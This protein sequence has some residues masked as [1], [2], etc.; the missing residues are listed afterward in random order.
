VKLWKGNRTDAEYELSNKK[1]A[2]RFV[3][4]DYFE[5][6]YKNTG[7]FG[8]AL[9]EFISNKNGLDSSWEWDEKKGSIDGSKDMLEIL[10]IIEQV[11]L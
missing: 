10:D 9:V 5:N 4:S 7:N 1:L 2:E 6:A 3:K 8:R 11:K